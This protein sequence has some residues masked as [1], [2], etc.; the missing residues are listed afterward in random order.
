VSARGM[1]DDDVDDQDSVDD[2]DNDKDDGADDQDAYQ[3]VRTRC[4]RCGRSTPVRAPEGYHFIV[5]SDEAAGNGDMADDF[6]KD[7][8]Q[9]HPGLRRRR[10][11][12]SCRRADHR[13]PLPI[14][15]SL[16]LN[17]SGGLTFE[18]P[19]LAGAASIVG[20]ADAFGP[21]LGGISAVPGGQGAR[22]VRA[23]NALTVGGNLR[24]R[25][26]RQE[27]AFV[28]ST[29]IQARLVLDARP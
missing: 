18:V 8:L 9:K 24:E 13:S 25:A 12:A 7:L 22:L 6:R 26:L 10:S 21:N 15:N 4:A 19:A 5:K 14:G 1:G 11:S 29:L 20:D 2:Q 17:V 28:P 27:R 23:G 3:L 16:T